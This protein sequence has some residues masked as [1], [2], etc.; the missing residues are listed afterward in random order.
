MVDTLF[1][2]Q[3]QNGEFGKDYVQPLPSWGWFAMQIETDLGTPYIG[4]FDCDGTCLTE[5]QMSTFATNKYTAKI[6]LNL[7]D[8]YYDS[9]LFARIYINPQTVEDADAPIIIGQSEPFIISES[10]QNIHEFQY[11]NNEQIDGVSYSNWYGFAYCQYMEQEPEFAIEE[12][13]YINSLNQRKKLSSNVSNKVNIKTNYIPNYETER[14]NL[15]AIH[16]VVL[17][18]SINYICSNFVSEGV[19]KFSLRPSKA[20][21]T[22]TIY[23]YQNNNCI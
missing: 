10:H 6:D 9:Q 19:E 1:K 14:L 8:A 12:T 2:Y 3:I 17:V 18:D 21:L 4:W 22:K 13:V 7:Q 15:I 11:S 5:W 16:D 20:N 23:N